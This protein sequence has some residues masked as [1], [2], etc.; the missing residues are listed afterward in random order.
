MEAMVG[1]TSWTGLQPAG[2]EQVHAEGVLLRRL[3]ASGAWHNVDH[4]WQASLMPV[5]GLVQRTD[6]YVGFVYK[7]YKTAFLTW[8]AKNVAVNLWAEDESASSLDWHT[9][10]TSNALDAWR[11]VPTRTVCPMRLFMEDQG[12]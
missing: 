12:S 11:V 10:L 8:P 4:A 7:A 2:Q 3:H 9:T 5:G 6:G 1:D